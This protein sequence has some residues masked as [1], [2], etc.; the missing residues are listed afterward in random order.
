M[1]AE[2]RLGVGLQLLQ[3]HRRDLGR[4]VL[5]AADVDA[6]VAVGAGDDLVGDD[7]LL[8]L[9]LG[10][11]A[12]HEALDREDRV[13]GVHHRLA[14]GDGA[15][16][17]LAG[18]GEG[19]HR[20][21]RAPALGVLDDLRLAALEDGHRGVRGTQVDSDRLAHSC[22]LLLSQGL[23]NLS[24][25]ASRCVSDRQAARRRGAMRAGLASDAQPVGVQ[26]GGSGFG[27][28]SMS[29]AGPLSIWPA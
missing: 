24:R 28:V 2:L 16:E 18:V 14:L 29:V 5:L 21:G 20:R 25:K 12:A 17:A 23:R 26:A 19:D 11:L 8:L 15:D 6:D 27:A 13:L 7:R 9:D 4:R 1:L 3:D 10:L 22:L